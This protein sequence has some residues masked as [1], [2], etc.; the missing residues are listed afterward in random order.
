MMG[1]TIKTINKKTLE[2]IVK[3]IRSSGWYIIIGVVNL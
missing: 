2:K 1:I 3:S